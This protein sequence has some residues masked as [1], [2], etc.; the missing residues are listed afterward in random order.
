MYLPGIFNYLNAIRLL[1]DFYFNS[2]NNNFLIL[3]D[4]VIL[5]S[6]I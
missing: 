5:Q 2:M 6:E 1:E 4:T 3:L